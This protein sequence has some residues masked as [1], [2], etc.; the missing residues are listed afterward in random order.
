MKLSNPSL[1]RPLF[2]GLLTLLV[3]TLVSMPANRVLAADAEKF[4]SAEAAVDALKGAVESS[5]TNRLHAI[6][7]PEAHE[8]VA[9]DVVEAHDER[10]LFMR[11][12]KE[13][14]NLVAESATK[15]ELQLGADGWPFP[16][17]LVKQDDKWFFD[18]DAGKEEVLNRR[19]GANELGTIEVCRAYVQAQ[20]EYASVDR[21]G[22]EVLEFAQ[23]LRSTPGTHDGLYW[24]TKSGDELSPLGPLITEAREEGYRKDAK[25]MADD[26]KPYHGYYFKVLTA[27][28]KHAPGGKFSYLIN[29]HLIAGFALVAWPAE[30][31]NTGI[32]TF[33]VNQQGKVYQKDLGPKSPL[34]ARAITAYDP[35]STWT[36]QK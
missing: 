10:D 33:I 28:G 5:D 2:R 18:V 30:W 4:G 1:V 29:G 31:G 32:M 6:F 9:A 11:R 27:Q 8:L 24:S 20:R 15:Q 25:I 7:G 17:P 12:V 14:I 22:D 21:D 26:Q 16:F 19:I 36:L 23:H 34:I 3:A 13:K 35:D